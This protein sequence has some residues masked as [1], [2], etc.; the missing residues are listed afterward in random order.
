ME[1]EKEG[2]GERGREKKD[3]TR[4]G[5]GRKS[6][7]MDV[8]EKAQESENGRMRGSGESWRHVE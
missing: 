3:K 5:E 2:M 8:L 6:E 7:N 4:I 1:G